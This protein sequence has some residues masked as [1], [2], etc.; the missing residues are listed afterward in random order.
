VFSSGIS[1]GR[2]DLGRTGVVGGSGALGSRGF[3]LPIGS[4]YRVVVC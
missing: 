4:G 3:V 1:Y 2:W